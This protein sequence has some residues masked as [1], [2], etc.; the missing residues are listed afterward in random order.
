MVLLLLWLLRRKPRAT[1]R[2]LVGFLLAVAAI[3]F[4]L[5]L[6][7]NTPLFPWLYE[8]VPTFDLFQAPTRWNLLTVFCL[9][10]LAGMASHAWQAGP[11]LGL[12]WVRL[13]IAGGLA[14]VASAALF[15]WQ[16]PQLEPSFLR[17]FIR[18]GLLIAALGGLAL[19]RERLSARLWQA[20]VIFLL[21]FD[22]ISA[23]WGL[24][25]MQSLELYRG[26]SALVQ[27]VDPLR[28]V[29][30]PSDLERKLKFDLTHRFDTFRIDLPWRAVRDMGL[31]NTTML[32][33]IASANNFDPMLPDHYVRFMDA[34]EA[35]P[36]TRQ[37]T[38]LRAMNV[39]AVAVED[40]HSPL[41]VR[42]EPLQGG[43]RAWLV[44]DAQW[45]E[46]ADQA[47]AAISAAPWDAQQSVVLIGHSA[48]VSA[49]GPGPVEGELEIVEGMDPGRLDINVRT[50][51]E[52]WLVLAD[53]W[54]PGWEA[55]ID[56]ATVELRRADYL[57]RAVRVPAGQHRVTMIYDPLSFRAGLALTLLASGVWL[58]GWILVRRERGRLLPR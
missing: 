37:T 50:G 40:P 3:A 28:R 27:Q 57:F 51:Q 34:L 26:P 7:A 53:L 5:G 14:M 39:G 25:P 36:E 56:G 12:K 4:S 30:M 29:W 49:A 6:G 31:P 41:G 48:A 52:A 13:G 44:A 21:G 8:H 19:L 45:V 32:E 1:E 20:G 15:A 38:L 9:A 54:Y 22:L 17:S 10:L 33:G 24:N 47:L 55:Q 18:L 58:C 23:G 2:G 16:V 43:R 35:L 11:L 42:Y 46:S